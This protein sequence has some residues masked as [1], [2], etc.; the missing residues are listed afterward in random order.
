MSINFKYDEDGYFDGA[1]DEPGPNTTTTPPIDLGEHTGVRNWYDGAKWIVIPCE[2]TADFDH[3]KTVMQDYASAFRIRTESDPK[4]S[5]YEKD[6]WQYQYEDAKKY[7][8]DES[9]GLFLQALHDESGEDLDTIAL[10][11]INKRE[12][13]L[14]DLAAQNARHQHLRKS[15][16]NATTREQLPRLHE[17]ILETMK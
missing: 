9:V 10:K 5:S 6:C 3:L 13:Y 2:Q 17:V 7:L 14:V 12:A 15:I 4:Y 1:T 11:I 16:E 8:E